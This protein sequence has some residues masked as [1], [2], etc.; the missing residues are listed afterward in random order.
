MDECETCKTYR[1]EVTK[2]A[3]FFHAEENQ[4][5]NMLVAE[6]NCSS[7][8][9]IQIC[10]YFD[11]QKIP[12]FAVLSQE[13]GMLHIYPGVSNRDYDFLLKFAIDGY[14]NAFRVIELPD[15]VGSFNTM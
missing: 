2:I 8:Q 5:F 4:D 3:N 14:K 7:D 11:I 6:I 10:Q 9:S 1:P 12:R 13:T 15:I